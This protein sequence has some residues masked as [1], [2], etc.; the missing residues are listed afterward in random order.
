MRFIILIILLAIGAAFLTKPKEAD[1]E[2]KLREQV[3]LDLAHEEIGEG[4]GTAENIALAACKLRPND[5]YELL[6]SG[7]DVTYTDRV[8][9]LMVEVVGFERQATCYGAFTTFFCPG[10]FKKI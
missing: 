8:L 6:R 2:A 4:R 3:F 5:C 1:A 10:G 7:L 9:F